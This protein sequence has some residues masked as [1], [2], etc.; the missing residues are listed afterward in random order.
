MARS[1]YAA[2]ILDW[3]GSKDFKLVDAGSGWPSI[4]EWHSEG[5]TIPL[6]LHIS[7]AGDYYRKPYEW[8]FQNPAGGKN[9]VDGSQGLPLLLGFDDAGGEPVLIL[10]DG[11]PRTG[12]KTRFSILFN[13]N[14]IA[15]AR[16]QGI[17]K[18][19]SKTPETM[20]AFRP[21]LLPT[22]IELLLA[23]EDLSP[24]ELREVSYASG[25]AHENTVA[26][27]ERTHRAAKVLVRDHRFGR[28]VRQAYGGE[29][30]MCG[31]G[32]GLTAGAHIYPVSA[33]DSPDVVSNGV[34]LCGNHHTAY[35]NFD[36]WFEP[37]SFKIRFSPRY[38][39]AAET[40]VAAA[41]FIQQT[42]SALAIPK[43]PRARPS[44][45]WI[46]ARREFYIE[47]YDWL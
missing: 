2:M 17:A 41:A 14:I 36:I 15:E 24:K 4:V 34:S 13:K 43:H 7:Q 16:Q 39:K 37:E 32:L 29:C 6:A 35:D 8:R 45:E 47:S 1:D 3:I 46:A 30:A 31:L 23:G 40:S 38:H 28:N 27:A 12:R 26:A 19:I 25:F 18:Y 21:K 5:N 11:R 9:P 33:P 42:Y 20:Y 22:V 10:A 44:A